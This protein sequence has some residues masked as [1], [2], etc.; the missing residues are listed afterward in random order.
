VV[1]G[2]KVIRHYGDFDVAAG[3]RSQIG[4][5]FNDTT[6]NADWHAA[7]SSGDQIYIAQ[8]IYLP[9]S[10]GGSGY[11]WLDIG[12]IQVTNNSGDNRYHTNPG[13]HVVGDGF[14]GGGA[15]H[16]RLDWG[17][18]PAGN[19][20]VESATPFPT[21]EWFD[22]EYSWRWST[23][24]NVT[25]QAWLNGALIITITGAQTVSSS[26]T[27]AELYMNLYGEDNGGSCSPRQMTMYRRNVRVS[28]SPL[29]H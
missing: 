1:G 16:L 24:T 25:L 22:L 10:I 19:D 20:E 23:S 17:N 4:I 12:G 26:Q 28:D 9:V 6:N 27:R 2:G 11:C 5:W 29:T 8:E 15:N 14:G 18:N 3:I 21:A 13:L 7:S